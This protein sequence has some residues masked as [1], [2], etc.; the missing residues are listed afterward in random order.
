MSL[1]RG[2]VMPVA[3]CTLAMTVPSACAQYP[4]DLQPSIAIAYGVVAEPDGTPVVD[5]VVRIHVRDQRECGG[6]VGLGTMQDGTDKTDAAG[7][8]RVVVKWLHVSRMERCLAVQA[9]PPAG[10]GLEEVTVTG[11]RVTFV[12]EALTP[13]AD[14][15]KVDLTLRPQG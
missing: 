11:A 3:V 9:I 2:G 8:Y 4:V 5:V 12:H 15:V 10:S 1:T 7:S 13:P 14:S 6:A